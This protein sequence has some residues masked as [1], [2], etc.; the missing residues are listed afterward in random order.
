MSVR[1]LSR[2]W[3]L[4]AV[5]ASTGAA[6][7]LI[8]GNESAT[9][10]TELTPD[11]SSE[12]GA[13]PVDGAVG[14][15]P[16]STA[17]ACVD[18]TGGGWGGCVGGMECVPDS[19]FSLVLENN[20]FT[21]IHTTAGGLVAFGTGQRFLV[22]DELGP[23]QLLDE[24]TA[25]D[26]TVDRDFSYVMSN[27]FGPTGDALLSL[28]RRRILDP[29]VQ[30]TWTPEALDGLGV[31]D[32]GEIRV[33]ATGP[34]QVLGVVGSPERDHISLGHVVVQ[35]FDQVA[36]PIAP[37]SSIAGDPGTFDARFDMYAL[38]RIQEK[39]DGRVLQIIRRQP[40][41]GERIPL[42]SNE[43]VTVE[44]SDA[45]LPGQGDIYQLPYVSLACNRT[46]LLAA[47]WGRLGV[48]H[49]PLLMAFGA[50]LTRERTF[51]FDSMLEIVDSRYSG[52][53]ARWS[54]AADGNALYVAR[55][56][57]SID[58]RYPTTP[59]EIFVFDYQLALQARLLARPDGQIR[60]IAVTD[61]YLYWLDA[62]GRLHRLLKPGAACATDAGR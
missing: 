53:V 44:T 1:V 26:L 42:D 21:R 43:W 14:L 51:D 58:A 52:G 30:E 60:Q 39:T 13:P 37:L 56:G 17:T 38:A 22:R 15:P 48:F 35:W 3:L 28:H 10:V 57:L 25:L 6:C 7:N 4:L 61:C 9:A 24:P 18:P 40:V 34:G 59:G 12:A 27:R 16:V 55:S 5:L 11:G 54:L 19:T 41:S 47:R 46:F 2:K 62:A 8:L 32:G 20:T 29:S 23:P 49:A 36:L 50:R 31:L 33:T 45:G